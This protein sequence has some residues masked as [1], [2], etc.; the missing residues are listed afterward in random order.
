MQ[1]YLWQNL[2]KIPSDDFA[3]GDVQDMVDMG[4]LYIPII[5][6]KERDGDWYI[7]L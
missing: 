4:K 6:R 3:T 5:H 7:Y 1:A 2:V